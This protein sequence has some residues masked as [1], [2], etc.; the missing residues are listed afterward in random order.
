M[1][2]PSPVLRAPARAR[3]AHSLRLLACAGVVS[4]LLAPAGLAPAPAGASDEGG[5]PG[6]VPG[7]PCEGSTL[8]PHRGL[9]Q[10]R[11]G[12]G[13]AWRLVPAG[14]VL[15]EGRRLEVLRYVREGSGEAAPATGRGWDDL[16]LLDP[17]SGEVVAGVR[18]GEVPAPGALACGEGR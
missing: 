3:R 11:A 4:L 18:A 15:R 8:F 16:V 10:P 1:T 9:L 7:L 6:G 12:E 5:L 17:W 14:S 13:G 2:R